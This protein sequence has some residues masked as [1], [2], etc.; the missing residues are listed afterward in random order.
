MKFPRLR[1]LFKFDWRQSAEDKNQ[2]K[3]EENS[4]KV[5]Q[6]VIKQEDCERVNRKFEADRMEATSSK[7]Q[8]LAAIAGEMEREPVTLTNI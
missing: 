6:K 4:E 1:R 8:Y 3:F 2:K 5:F 7:N